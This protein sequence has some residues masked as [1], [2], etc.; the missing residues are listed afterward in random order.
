MR[1][2][3]GLRSTQGFT[4]VELVVVIVVMAV[5]G[6]G[7]SQFIVN[8]SDSYVST[9]LRDRQGSAARAVVER[10]S[11]ELRNALP[12][13]VRVSA[14]Q[15]CLE[16]VPVLGGSI[17]TRIPLTSASSS[18]S[19]IPFSSGAA[20]SIGR[21]AVYPINTASVYNLATTSA[22]MSSISPDVSSSQSALED[23][24]EIDVQLSR[25]HRFPLES[26]SQRWFMVDDP[27][28]FCFSG[29]QLFR[30]RDYDYLTSQPSPGGFGSGN[31]QTPKRALLANGASGSFVV[32][33]AT[34]QRNA[35][36]QMNL[37][38]RERGE[39][40]SIV[41]EVQLRNAP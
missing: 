20:P 2:L 17:Y 27:V 38:L 16:F 6:V 31:E 9:A 7:V 4:L 11:R 39:G 18:F 26:P 3:A 37:D 30:Y 23:T 24:V 13:S 1:R 33:P 22:A 28:S 40:V 12:N 19:S 15:Q 5:L 8:T 14:D 21:V 34:L 41:H 25:A 35:L 32:I 10:I 29:T 36:V